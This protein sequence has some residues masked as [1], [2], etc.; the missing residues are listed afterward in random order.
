MKRK[1][2]CIATPIVMA[3]AMTAGSVAQAAPLQPDQSRTALVTLEVAGKQLRVDPKLAEKIKSP[4]G[5][6]DLTIKELA[7]AGIHPGM[8]KP[9]VPLPPQFGSPPDFQVQSASGCDWTSGGGSVCIYVRGTGLMV[10][11]WDASAKRFGYS[12]TYAAY[13]HQGVII[14]TSNQSCGEGTAWAYWHPNSYF[15]PGQACNTFVRYAGKP[16]VNITR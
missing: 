7:S 3:V 15:E 14:A 10:N 11:D 4:A 5:W 12:C 1:A 2:W 16:C 9:G 8:R 6:K 13:W